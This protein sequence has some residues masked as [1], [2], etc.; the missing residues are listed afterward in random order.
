MVRQFDDSKWLVKQ[1][2]ALRQ[3]V[4]AIVW[5]FQMARHEKNPDP[6]FDDPPFHDKGDLTAEDRCLNV[7][8]AFTEMTASVCCVTFTL[9][10][11]D[12]ATAGGYDGRAA[13]TKLTSNIRRLSLPLESGRTIRS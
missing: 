6:W 3:G 7:V 4:S 13:L 2:A 1:D 8:T 10:E 5:P 12:L 11:M 9:T